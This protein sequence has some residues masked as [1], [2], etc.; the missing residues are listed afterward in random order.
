[1]G[2]SHHLTTVSSISNDEM[3]PSEM[4]RVIQDNTPVIHK[5]GKEVIENRK[6]LASSDTF[7][8]S[9]SMKSNKDLLS[10][11]SQLIILS[12]LERAS[13]VLICLVL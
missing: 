8:N 11:L 5:F 13:S 6:R 12:P 7:S 1:M 4:F 9:Q 10:R 3:Q 2:A